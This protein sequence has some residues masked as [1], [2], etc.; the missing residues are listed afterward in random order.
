MARS[1]SPISLLNFTPRIDG[2]KTLDRGHDGRLIVAP[3]KVRW[4]ALP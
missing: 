2:L 3:C 4:L 1:W